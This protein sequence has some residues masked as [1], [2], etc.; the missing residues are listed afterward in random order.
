MGRTSGYGRSW[1]VNGA[2]VILLALLS[3][4]AAPDPYSGAE[5]EQA[6]SSAAL[7]YV[8]LIHP[9]R[10]VDGRS[11]DVR[12]IGATTFPPNVT[13]AIETLHREIEEALERH[14]VFAVVSSDPAEL[15]TRGLEPELEVEVAIERAKSV[16]EFPH[17]TTG[18]KWVNLVLW[19]FA[20]APGW[21]IEDT[22]VHPGVTAVTCRVREN[23]EGGRE[24]LSFNVD[25][26]EVNKLNFVRRASWA[27]YLKQV[28]VPPFLVGSDPETV[29]ESLWENY[30][31][32]IQS[33][34]PRSIKRD[35]LRNLVG[36]APLLLVASPRRVNGEYIAGA[37]N[38]DLLIFADEVPGVVTVHAL[39]QQEDRHASRWLASFE[40][41]PA[42]REE[43]LPIAE[44]VL[45]DD[46]EFL[47]GYRYKLRVMA[48]ELLAPLLAGNSTILRFTVGFPSERRVVE[49]SWTIEY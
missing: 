12:P 36:K 33:G 4:C 17:Q 45:L 37:Q 42:P 23:G 44:S 8:A 29:A 2:S 48:G 38:L 27:E 20:G 14:K 9:V 19:L 30:V 5:Y 32:R 3:A 40:P 43:W 24:L 46:A 18:M 1:V 49:R 26:A 31:S 10:L 39:R 41:D 6:S 16:S 28:I 15:D 7:P 21:I 25:L 34:V 47:D 22:Y 11:G 35:L 13:P